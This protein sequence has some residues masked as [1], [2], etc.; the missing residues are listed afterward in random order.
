M[1]TAV[2]PVV[3]IVDAVVMPVIVPVIRVD[4]PAWT[5][6]ARIEIPIGSIQRSIPD[7]DAVTD[8]DVVTNVNVAC[9]WTIPTTNART[10]DVD[11]A[12]IDV[13]SN[14]GPVDIGQIVVGSISTDNGSIPSDARTICSC[15]RSLNHARQSA[16]PFATD[17]G[18]IDVA[19]KRARAIRPNVR[20]IDGARQSAWPFGSDVRSIDVARKSAWSIRPDVRAIRAWCGFRQISG[21]IDRS[22]KRRWP[23]GVSQSRSVGSAWTCKPT[24]CSDVGSVS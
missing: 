16:W 20:A 22:W 14:A 10:I 6:E 1:P 17:V 23:I 9:P 5:R 15:A 12:V 8:V 24:T 2:V 18:S 13:V 7:I 3:T 4:P 21:L 19:G 11:V